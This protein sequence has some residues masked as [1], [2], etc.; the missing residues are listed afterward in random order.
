MNDIEVQ[1]AYD[2]EEFLLAFKSNKPKVVILDWGS[3]DETQSLNLANE[4]SKENVKVIFTSSYLNKKEILKSGADL[5][6]PKPY[7]INDIVN[8]IKKFLN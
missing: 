3:K 7:E 6:I 2:K 1:I 5:Y 8:W 4:I